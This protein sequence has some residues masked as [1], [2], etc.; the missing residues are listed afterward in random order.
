M[1]PWHAGLPEATE[2]SLFPPAGKVRAYTKDVDRTK[3]MLREALPDFTF[4]IAAISLGPE[5]ELIPI[6]GEAGEGGRGMYASP[7]SP[8]RLREIKTALHGFDPTR[9][10]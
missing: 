5:P 2:F 8:E 1:K 6:L 4:E 10:S 3:A 9:A 7:P